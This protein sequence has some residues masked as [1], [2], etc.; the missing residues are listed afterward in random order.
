MSLGSGRPFSASEVHRRGPHW[1]NN[2]AAEL[3]KH[4]RCRLQCPHAVFLCISVAVIPN[5]SHNVKEHLQRKVSCAIFFAFMVYI[6]VSRSLD[7]FAMS[8]LQ[9]PCI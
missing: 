7:H 9:W 8:L 3:L 6:E 5:L 1:D 2:S 4:V